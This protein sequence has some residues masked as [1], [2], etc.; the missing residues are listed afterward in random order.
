MSGKW[1][2]YGRFFQ[3][4][5]RSRISIRMKNGGAGNYPYTDNMPFPAAHPFEWRPGEAL[6]NCWAVCQQVGRKH[7]ATQQ[8]VPKTRFCAPFWAT[9]TPPQILQSQRAKAKG[10]KSTT[11]KPD[12]R[13]A[14]AKGLVPDRIY[15]KWGLIQCRY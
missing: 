7:V 12:Q 9:D 13:T 15:L 10:D 8:R 3:R 5:P 6:P 1:N 14:A 4:V 11:V 2:K